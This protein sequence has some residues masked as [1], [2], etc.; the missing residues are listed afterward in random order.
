MSVDALLGTFCTTFT[1][2]KL[3]TEGSVE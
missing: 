1:R 3:E 2:S